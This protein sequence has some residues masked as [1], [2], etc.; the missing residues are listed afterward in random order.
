[1]F[2]LHPH[3]ASEIIQASFT[4]YPEPMIKGVTREGK[5]SY[6]SPDKVMGSS[7]YEQVFQDLDTVIALYDIPPGT[8]FPHINGFFS[9][10]LADVTEDASGWIFARGGNACLAYR[11]LAP[12]HWIKYLHHTSGWAKERLDLGGR[13]LTSPHLRNGTIVQAASAEEFRDFDAFKAAIR[14]L[15]L[16]FTLTP[17][18][19]VTFTTLR[20]RKIGFTHGQTPTVDGR[21]VDHTRWKLFEGPHLNA[22]VGGRKLT[23]THGRLERVLDFNTLTI[24]DHVR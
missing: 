2:S 18:P 4:F 3:S 24:T 22:E 6:D 17:A 1:M 16:E 7:P 15:P 13:I 11:P 19:A 5:P 23:L 12:Y 20:G 9:K 8:R 10:D 21:P 14:A